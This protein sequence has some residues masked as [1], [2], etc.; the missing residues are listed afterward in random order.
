MSD[1]NQ[2]EYQAVIM[3]ALLHDLIYRF[4]GT[5]GKEG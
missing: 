3:G 2:R 4:V 1:F 5:E